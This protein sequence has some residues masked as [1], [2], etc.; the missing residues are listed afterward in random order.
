MPWEIIK[1]GSKHCVIRSDTRATVHCHPSQQEAADHLS[2]LYANEKKSL[3]EIAVTT[4]LQRGKPLL[5][6]TS[7]NFSIAELEVALATAET[8][9]PINEAEGNVEQATLER[10]HAESFREAIQLL[11][12]RKTL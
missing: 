5:R 12:E 1:R 8:N 3:Q 7:L 6:K 4:E 11:A 2:A 9:A 10:R